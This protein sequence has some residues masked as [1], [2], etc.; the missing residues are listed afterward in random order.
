MAC[1]ARK[2]AVMT[3][4]QL[5]ACDAMQVGG[6]LSPSVAPS[7]SSKSSTSGAGFSSAMPTPTTSATAARRS[8]FGG[9]SSRSLENLAALD[10][11][12]GDMTAA[13]A[14]RAQRFSLFNS[15]KL[16][17][18]MMLVC[19][20]DHAGPRL[21]CVIIMVS[22]ARSNTVTELCQVRLIRGMCA[23]QVYVL[24]CS[25]ACNG[26]RSWSVFDHSCD[27]VQR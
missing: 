5:M 10:T 11:P 26:I 22:C 2:W 23:H 9:A 27:C 1:L 12:A 16:L 14:S 7:A 17:C 21:C 18:Q 24:C 15:C 25:T 3:I 4:F 13:Q 8:R 20:N 6:S 19:A